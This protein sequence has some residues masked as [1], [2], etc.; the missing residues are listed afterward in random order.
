MSA[1]E[2]SSE[3]ERQLRLVVRLLSA[4][5]VKGMSRKESILTLVAAGLGPK[6]VADQLGVSANQVSVTVYEARQAVKRNPSAKS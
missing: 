4:L 2:E 3:T 5:L 6:E 1:R